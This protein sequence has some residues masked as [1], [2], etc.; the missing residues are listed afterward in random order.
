MTEPTIK[1]GTASAYFN[2]CRCD[3]CKEAGRLHRQKGNHAAFEAGT[4]RKPP[5]FMLGDRTQPF[6]ESDSRHGSISAYSM[7]CRC[8]KCKDAGKAYREAR[9]E[10]AHA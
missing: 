5:L 10:K 6:D 9:K 3:Q 8:P 2:G 4:A 7:G 1:H